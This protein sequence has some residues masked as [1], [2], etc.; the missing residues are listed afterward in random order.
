MTRVG[1]VSVGR[2]GRTSIRNVRFECRPRHPRACAHALEYRELAYRPDRR[3]ADA[4]C[5]TAAP[6]RADGAPEFLQAGELLSR[7]RVVL[8]QLGKDARPQL[9]RVPIEVVPPV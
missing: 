8:T 5:R 6:P 1:A 3:Q 7:R 9:G 2:I 4:E